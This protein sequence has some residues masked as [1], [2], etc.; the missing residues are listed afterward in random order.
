MAY[1][2]IHIALTLTT[3]A[4]RKSAKVRMAT[5]ITAK[6][7]DNDENNKDGAVNHDNDNEEEDDDEDDDDDDDDR[8]RRRR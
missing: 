7:C 4:T 3:I 8:R 5:T 1:F 2:H 6:S